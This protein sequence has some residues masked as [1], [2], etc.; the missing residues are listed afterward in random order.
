[1]SQRLAFILTLCAVALFLLACRTANLLSSAEPTAPPARV[2]RASQRPTF[3]PIPTETEIPPPTETP[4]PTEPPPTDE[5]TQPPPPT[6]RPPTKRPPTAIPP[7]Q[8]PP[9]PTPQ[10]SPTVFFLWTT[11]GNASCEGGSD[12]ESS[13]SGKITANNKGAVGQRVQASSGA[14]GSPISDNPAESNAD[15][16][17]KV[18]FI[19]GGKACNGDFWIWMADPSGRQ[20][21]PFVK[22]H[23]DGGCRK[24][25]QNF[26]KR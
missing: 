25:T 10:P 14:G 6:K 23:F 16:N 20:I 12:S 22:F 2:T 17:Y 1:M 8:P 15:G 5:P 4:E 24:G 13:V 18:T 19:C 9:P 26:Q 7:T 3:T 11:V 21:S